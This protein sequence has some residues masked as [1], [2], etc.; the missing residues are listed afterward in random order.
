MLSIGTKNVSIYRNTAD[1]VIYAGPA[2]D[3][4]NVDTVSL[5]RS[6]PVKRGSDNGTMRGNM[7]FAKSF[8]NG[9]KKSLVVVNL[10]AHVPVGVD[11]TAVRTWMTSEVFPGA[12]SSVTLDLA[13]KGVIHLSDA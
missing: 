2:H 10:T 5:R 11:A 3:V 12:T 6:L 9:D 1:E 13:T 4:T 8:P 7:N